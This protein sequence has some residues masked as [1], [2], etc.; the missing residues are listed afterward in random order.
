MFIGDDIVLVRQTKEQWERQFAA[1]AWDR[2]QEG[3]PNTIELARCI[4]TYARAKKGHIRVLDVGCGNGG[5]ARLLSKK[6][7]IAYTGI[8]ISEVALETAHM[9]APEGYFV[10]GDAEEPP[11]DIGA[12]D[13]LVFSEVLYYMNPDRV[14]PRYRIHATA[15]ARVF[16]SVVRF[17]RTPF[18]F[19]RI[20]RYLHIDKRFRVAD[21]S[22]RWDIAIGH[23]I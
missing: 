4:L 1:G 16:V 18:V 3:Q 8:D 11:P 9:S 17:W 6:S 23:F 7:G 5:L 20:R 21:S 14:L 2:L 12:F 10:T 22:H 15:D 19:H 13:I